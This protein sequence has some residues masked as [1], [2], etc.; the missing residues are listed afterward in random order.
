MLGRQ[1]AGW[2]L[3]ALGAIGVVTPVL[4]GGILFGWGAVILAPDVR[5]I[6]RLLDR[7]SVAQLRSAI[8]RARGDEKPP[9]L[10][11][12]VSAYPRTGIVV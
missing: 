3:L 10:T 6:G 11:L 9:S 8:E 2:R 4:P 1:L 5:I 7:L 12:T